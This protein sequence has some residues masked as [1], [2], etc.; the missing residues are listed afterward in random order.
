M[1]QQLKKRGFLVALI[2]VLILSVAQTSHAQASPTPITGF[3]SDGATYLIEVPSDWNGTL[4][5]YS[6]GYVVARKP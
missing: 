5:L 6:H 4:F 2:T 1:W 3:L